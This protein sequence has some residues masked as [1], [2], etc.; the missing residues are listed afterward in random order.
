MFFTDSPFLE[1]GMGRVCRNILS[2]WNTIEGI[3][4]SCIGWHQKEPALL[5]KIPVFPSPKSGQDFREDTVRHESAAVEKA[6][7][8]IKPDLMITLGDIWDFIYMPQMQERYGFKWLGYY[9]VDSEPIRHEIYDRFCVPTYLAT[10]SGFGK[11]VLLN[12]DPSLDIDVVYHGVD[13]SIFIPLNLLE[14]QR[15]L[16]RDPKNMAQ[17]DSLSNQFVVLMDSQNTYRKAYPKALEAFAEFGRD[18]N[19]VKLIIV[20]EAKPPSKE[21]AALGFTDVEYFIKHTHEIKPGQ[22]TIYANSLGKN[23]TYADS[24]MNYLYNISNVYMSVSR[25]EGFGLSMLQ[26][27]ATKT[28]PLATE[29]ASYPELMSGRGVG[30]KVAGFDYDNST[31]RRLALIDKDDCV[32]KLQLLY[33]DWETGGKIANEIHAA[34]LSFVQQNTWVHSAQKLIQTVQKALHKNTRLFYPVQ[35]KSAPVSFDGLLRKY[36]CKARGANKEGE[37]KICMTVMGGVG[38]NLQTLPIVRG[39][40]RKYP[41]SKLVVVCEANSFVFADYRGN[42]CYH[43]NMTKLEVQ[44]H[45]FAQV[46]KTLA[47]AFDIY[48]DIRYVS[49]VYMRDENYSDFPKESADFFNQHFGYY[50]RWPWGNNRIHKIGKHVIDIRLISAGLQKYGSVDDMKIDV[51]EIEKPVGK[52]VTINNGAGGVGALKIM[53]VEYLNKVAGYLNK[54]GYSVVQLGMRNETKI[55]GAIDL[56]GRTNIWQSGYLLRESEIYIG[57][58]GTTFHICKASGGRSLVWQT[59]TPPECFVYPDTL[60]LPSR[61]STDF[62]CQPCWW[63]GTDY[64]LNN[65]AQGLK[66]CEN[67][68]TG[69]EIITMLE[70]NGI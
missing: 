41:G 6:V 9:N 1:S 60:V 12:C 52:F 39:I 69:E 14:K 37:K 30:I 3:E 61:K 20:A 47:S 17:G 26:A 46:L 50:D 24:F 65:C 55:E 8:E 27:M 49:R 38:D 15:F 48:Y 57:P 54:K 63:Q 5:G 70:M 19:N 36:A 56:R 45:S 64:F 31:Y 40:A 53:P 68:P 22:C 42:S 18:K 66:V 16:Y 25:A 34:G 21:M 44:G 67:M 10:T 7:K 33:E 32:K 13:L 4:L 28:V 59:V 29:Y 58:E 35:A 23:V 11:R 62:K 43:P 51:Q 2:V